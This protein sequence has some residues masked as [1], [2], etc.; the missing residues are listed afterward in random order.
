MKELPTTAE[1]ARPRAEPPPAVEAADGKTVGHATVLS[2]G[3]RSATES[4]CTRTDD[5]S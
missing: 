5:R 4:G 1:I 3:S 2:D